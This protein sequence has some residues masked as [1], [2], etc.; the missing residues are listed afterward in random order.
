MVI[1]NHSG[2]DLFNDGDLRLVS[3]NGTT[4]GTSG[5]LEVYYNFQWGTVCDDL[6]E[7]DD[8]VVAC[9]QLGFANLHG[10]TTLGYVV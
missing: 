1:L 2:Q 10:L 8:G 3:N 7:L 5:R 9:R 6:F 4:G